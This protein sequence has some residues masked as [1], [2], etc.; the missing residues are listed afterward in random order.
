MELSSGQ[1]LTR[2]LHYWTAS[3]VLLKV[4]ELYIFLLLSTLFFFASDCRCML[5]YKLK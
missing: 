2:T 4:I 1:L 5:I 3:N